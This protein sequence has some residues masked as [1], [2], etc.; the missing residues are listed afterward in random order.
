MCRG[1]EDVHWLA[2]PFDSRPSMCA[3]AQAK[4]LTGSS[5]K[6]KWA[7]HGAATISEVTEV[8]AYL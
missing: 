3:F 4:K 5:E 8:L 6:K 2:L 7:T 1:T